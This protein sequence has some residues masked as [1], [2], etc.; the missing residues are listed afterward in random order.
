MKM[1]YSED[2][3]IAGQSHDTWR[4]SGLIA[5]SLMSDP[6]PGVEIV[7]PSAATAEQLCRVH[8]RVYVESVRRARPALWTS[9][10]ASTGG[11]LAA[12]KA[13]MENGVAGSLSS[14]LHHAR[15]DHDSGFCTFNGLALAAFDALEAGAGS[16]LVLDFDAHCGGG[17]WSLIQDERRIVQIDVA[18]DSFDKYEPS[19]P[20]TLDLVSSG[21][22]YLSVIENRL[23]DVQRLSSGLGLV[24]YNAGMDPFEG[25]DL[26]ALR[27]ITRDVLAERERLVFE[28]CR[29]CELPVAFVLAGGYH[30]AGATEASIVDLHR[31]TISAAARAAAGEVA[32]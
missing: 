15:R 28:Y 30:G 12:V 4:K 22:D 9:A 27:G 1:Y 8:D 3:V 5:A 18:V 23:R 20:S 32:R 2:Y 16:V 21:K 10:C 17:T 13:A 24:L 11:V 6:I 7:A 26:G 29:R 14:G 31:L 25:N 19:P